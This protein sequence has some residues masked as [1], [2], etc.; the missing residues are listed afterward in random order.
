MKTGTSIEDGLSWGARSRGPKHSISY[1][2]KF[3]IDII[4]EFFFTLLR[5]QHLL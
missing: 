2:S 3:F 4:E 5:I 1:F